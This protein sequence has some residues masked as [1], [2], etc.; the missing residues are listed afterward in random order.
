M[1]ILAVDGLPIIIGCGSGVVTFTIFLC[2]GIAVWL[3]HVPAWLPTISDCAVEAPEKYPFRLGI[4]TGALLLSLEVVAVYHS[5]RKFSK[6]KLCLYLGCIASLG[7]A[8]VGV[9]NEKED[10]FIHTSK[11]TVFIHTPTV[12]SIIHSLVYVCIYVHLSIR[13]LYTAEPL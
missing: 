13:M 4:V 5:D 12:M 8:V 11:P 9:V 7:L 2:Y 10:N 6:N 1:H 3:G